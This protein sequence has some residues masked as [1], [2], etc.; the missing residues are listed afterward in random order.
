MAVSKK[1]KDKNRS[2]FCELPFC[3]TLEAESMGGEVNY[4]DETNGPRAKAYITKPFPMAR[5]SSR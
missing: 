3:H 2:D 4:G 1:L 5:G